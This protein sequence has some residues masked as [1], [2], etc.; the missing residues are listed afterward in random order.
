MRGYVV[1][2]R[3]NVKRKQL[4]EQMPTGGV[5]AEIGVWEGDFSARIL[6]INKPRLLHLVDPWR[7]ESDEVYKDAWYGGKKAIN[8]EQMDAVYDRVTKRFATQVRAGTVVIHRSASSEA[9]SA[10]A[11]GYFDWIY[12]DGNH[13]YEF[14]KLDLEL[15][16]PKVKPGGYITGDDYTDREDLWYRGG[17]KKAV[18]DFASRNNYEPLIIGRQFILKVT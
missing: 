9:V 6:E 13:L 14:V 5:C 15:W 4:L 18:D 2:Q 1:A 8:Q 17:V 7:Y 11:D 16:R 12:I 10:F 3:L